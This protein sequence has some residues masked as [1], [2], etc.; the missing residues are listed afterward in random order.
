MTKYV[1]KKIKQDDI[2]LL[3]VTPKPDWQ[4]FPEFVKQF[5]QDENADMVVQDYGMDR[6]QVHFDLD[7]Q[8]YILQY[9]HYTDSVWVEL[10]SID[11]F[12]V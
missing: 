10:E 4:D 1:Y 8:R 6:H 12:P 9:E 7:G 3:D 2:V 5:I 11:N